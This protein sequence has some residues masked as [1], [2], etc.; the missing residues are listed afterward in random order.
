M[1]LPGMHLPTSANQTHAAKMPLPSLGDRKL[2][3]RADVK[4]LLPPSPF[5]E[6]LSLASTFLLNKE[7]TFHIC[8]KDTT[9]P[10][11]SFVLR[12]IM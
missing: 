9:V 12:V 6:Q 5:N 8:L 3:I 1:C 7:T 11:S 4:M 10:R 2:K